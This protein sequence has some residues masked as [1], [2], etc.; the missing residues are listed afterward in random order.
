M[1]YE[2]MR[3]EKEEYEKKLEEAKKIF[4]QRKI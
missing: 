2:Q 3:R 4:E 1:L